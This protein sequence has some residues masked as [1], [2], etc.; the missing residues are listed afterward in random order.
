MSTSS[1]VLSMPF[2]AFFGI[3]ELLLVG[4]LGADV[5]MYFLVPDVA[6]VCSCCRK[7]MR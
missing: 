7:I 6:A 5:Q 2:S 4:T 1:E 3:K